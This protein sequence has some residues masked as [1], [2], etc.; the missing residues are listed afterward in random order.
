MYSA[1][2]IGAGQIAGGYDSPGDKAILT[3]AH[4]YTENP[5]IELL[6][7]YDVNFE[8]AKKMADKWDTKALSFSPSPLEGE[9]RGEGLKLICA[10]SEPISADIISICVPD[11]FHTKTVLDAEK[12]NPKLI[13]LEKPVCRDLKDIEIL[14]GVKTPILVNYSRSFSKSFRKLSERIKSGEFGKY[15]S[16]FGYYGKGFTHNGSHMVNLMNLLIGEVSAVEFKD[17]IKDFYEDDSSKLAIL[18]FKQGGRFIMNPVDCR[19]YTVFELDMIFENARIKI[20]NSGYKIEIFKAKESDKFKGYKMPELTE[21][22]NTDLDFALKN[23]VENAV[24]YLNG[25]EDLFCTL[26]NGIE[27]I[28]INS[29]APCGR[30]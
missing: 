14:K 17:E 27:A 15:E 5:D 23:A 22:I 9:G 24:N 13:F 18:T 30:G 25:K 7:F 21:E 8:A 12:L 6:G 2:I 10:G 1:L 16:G 20:L 11:E 4:A 29:L 28:Y 3:H 19:N 26:Q